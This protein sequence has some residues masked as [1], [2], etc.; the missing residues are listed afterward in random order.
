[1]SVKED[2]IRILNSS[3]RVPADDEELAAVSVNLI[4]AVRELQNAVVHLAEE[5]DRDRDRRPA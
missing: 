4:A 2:V 5:I 3:G 1:M